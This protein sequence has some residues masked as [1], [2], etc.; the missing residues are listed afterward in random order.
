MR[1]PLIPKKRSM[2]SLLNLI[3]L[4]A[5]FIV[6][7][8]IFP[9]NVLSHTDTNWISM[10]DWIGLPSP[11]APDSERPANPPHGGNFSCYG[12][13]GDVTYWT[14]DGGTVN[15]LYWIE[16]CKS[17]YMNMSFLSN[18][19]ASGI[20]SFILNIYMDAIGS[21]PQG[22]IY[23]YAADNNSIQSTTYIPVTVIPGWN[24][25][26]V[27]SL[28]PSMSGFGFIKFRFVQEG[29]GD[30]SLYEV[31]YSVIPVGGG[32][33]DPPTAVINGPYTGVENQPVIF[34]SAGSSDPN[35][36]TLKYYYWTF[37]NGQISDLPNPTAYFGPG[38]Y[39]VTLTVTDE[40]GLTNQPV[41]TTA[42]IAPDNTVNQPPIAN[43]G[44]DRTVQVRAATNFDGSSSYDPEGVGL[45]FSWNFGD[46]KTATGIAVTH[47]YTKTG[48][49]TVTLTVTDDKGATATDTAIV[50]VV[51]S[52]VTKG[53]ISGNVY[54]GTPPYA[55]ISSA[56]VSITDASGQGRSML[57]DATGSY[58][59]ADVTIGAFSGTVSKSGYVSQGIS[60]TVSAGQ[61]TT[62]SVGLSS[63]YGTLTGKVTDS[64]TGL[65]IPAAG[66]S[67]TDGGGAVHT[68]TTDASGTYIMPQMAVGTFTGTASKAGY[69]SRTFSGSIASGQT[70]TLNLFLFPYGRIAGTVTDS[71]TS[72]PISSA[73]MSITDA[74]GRSLGA[75]TDAN[76]SFTID[77]VA[78]G[79]FSGTAV[80][81]NYVTQNISGTVTA[82]QTATVN[83]GL[84]PYGSVT[85]K[86]TD[87][88]SGLPVSLANVNIT[89]AG[90]NQHFGTT[91][92]AGMYTIANVY[93]GTFSGNVNLTGY[94]TA[95]ISGNVS[96]GQT[97]T[98]NVALVPLSG[99]IRGTIT[100]ALT[101]S[102]IYL[103]E[104]SVTDNAGVTGSAL[105]D[106]G[107]V[108]TI[109]VN[110]S[111]PFTG[112]VMKANYYVANISGTVTIPQST[113]KDVQLTP[114]KGTVSGRVT[115]AT[116][117]LPINA[118]SVSVVDSYNRPSSTAT[119]N[120]GRYTLN[121]VTEGGFTGTVAKPGYSSAN[122]SG[123]VFGGQTTTVDVVLNPILPV[124]SNLQTS[125]V[126]GTSA[127]F[128]WT[129]DQ[130]TDSRVDYGLAVFYDNTAY[131]SAMTTTHSMT[132]AGLTPG[133]TY[134]FK[135]TSTNE[136]ELYASSTDGTFDTTGPITI[137]ITYPLDNSYV[138]KV[139][140]TFEGTVTNS[141]GN[142]TG[143]VVNGVLATVFGDRFVANDVPLALGNNV[144]T[145]N[146]TDTAG[147]TAA[148]SVTVVTMEPPRYTQ[149]NADVKTGLAPM[150]T[151][152]TFGGTIYPAA[153]DIQCNGPGQVEVLDS[154]V[155][156]YHIRMTT[157]GIY[158][159]SAAVTGYDGFTYEDSI[160]IVALNATVMDS[161]LRDKWTDMRSRM[162]QED[163]TGAL[164]YIHPANK[165]NYRTIFTVLSGQLALIA[166]ED[167]GLDFV[168]FRNSS[169]EYTLRRIENGE[170]FSY[171]VLFQRDDKGLW[172]ILEH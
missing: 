53:A 110:H 38:T 43:A 160:Y 34:N 161:L 128:T 132:L 21:P 30:I 6:L 159:C 166:S 143:V 8:I 157:E 122:I 155:D 168:S 46:G 69:L 146:A 158:R 52:T 114:F 99:F 116:S 129:T 85:G 92:S 171:E 127:T 59:F 141:L 39:T 72:T 135:V 169:A 25:I 131:S 35:G 138:S 100:D 111:G 153:T 89:D 104:V 83:V 62:V 73:T 61:I 9:R 51:S 121:D 15:A 144:I 136:Y 49:Y 90:G 81:A 137:I 17:G 44:P 33:N 88:I 109:S 126:S 130:L 163:A 12:P 107:G 87:S 56:N 76:G 164:A 26:D 23:A 14:T 65:A 42:T 63:I 48:T 101:G 74:S 113:I 77:N 10:I 47:S 93:P 54:E 151:T 19:E 147:Y 55:R 7:Q 156:Q 37:G 98:L 140:V 84:V 79:A 28:L 29:Q 45:S 71:V 134:H 4:F 154:N 16:K 82:G 86:V 80:K 3:I 145:A 118:A 105:T 170:N 60:G 165:E 94:A 172:K 120:T 67:V 40:H 18:Y 142:E 20:S 115:D 148:T 125:N 2:F 150:E 68:A 95:N 108:Y 57:T 102:P 70:T 123:N 96:P 11:T 133:R 36:D 167:T 24:R 91:T 41:S 152:L 162:T 27:T 106:S 13:G 1:L 32:T 5:V 124:I 97:T 31:Y 58:S 22:R 64:T 119:D 66:V 78:A 75:I 112:T 139:S 149:L 103:A 117:G 50:T